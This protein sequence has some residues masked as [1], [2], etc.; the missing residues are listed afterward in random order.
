MPKTVKGADRTVNGWMLTPTSIPPMELKTERFGKVLQTEGIVVPGSF[1]AEKTN[2]RFPANTVATVLLDQTYLTNAYPTLVFSGGKGA[3]I[4]LEYAEALFTK[5]PAKGNRNETGGKQMI[6]RKDSI[7][8]DGSA[9][10]IFTTLSFRTYRFVQVTVRTQAEPL[11]LE[12]IYGTFTGYPFQFERNPRI[13]A[14]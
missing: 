6:G 14:P 8:S 12:D 1:P 7:L 11:V 9:A 3:S 2:L 5:Y 4:S 13:G 10:Q